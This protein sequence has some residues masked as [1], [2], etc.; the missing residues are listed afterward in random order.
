MRPLATTSASAA[1]QRGRERTGPDVLVD[2]DAGRVSG[3]EHRADLVHVVF[4]DQTRRRALEDGE[5]E[6]AVAVEV[7]DRDARNRSVGALLDE[8]EVDDPDDAP[9]DQVDE[10]GEA[11]A[12]QLVR[13]R[14]LD[15]QIV[16]RAH[17]VDVVA[18]AEPRSFRDDV[19][20]GE[21]ARSAPRSKKASSVE[22]GT[23]RDGPRAAP[24]AMPFSRR[25]NRSRQNVAEA[26]SMTSLQDDAL[27][28]DWLGLAGYLAEAVVAGDV[29]VDAARSELAAAATGVAEHRAL[30]RAAE[31]ATTQFGAE[32]L[33]AS[34]LQWAAAHA[35]AAEVA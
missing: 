9:V 4:A 20:A 21:T 18:H 2:E 19:K 32:S 22:V 28:D 10:V 15:D 26:C 30:I 1:P 23:T 5:I 31:I 33:V 16:D 3:L 27:R 17:L 25:V 35:V 34:L 6:L 13:V 7:G 11:L 8:R 24:C 12:G 29:S 14:E